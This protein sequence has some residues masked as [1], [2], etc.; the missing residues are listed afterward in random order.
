MT[1]DTA[2]ARPPEVVCP[3]C[4]EAA[5]DT[6]SWCE[7]CGADLDASPAVATPAADCVSCGAPP[8]EIADDGY[9][10]HC[11]HKQPSRRDHLVIDEGA[12]A[13]VSDR[14]IRHHQN[15][16]A[17]AFATIRGATIVVVCDGVSSTDHAEEASQ[18]AAD[19]AVSAIVAAVESDPA[20]VEAALVAGAAASQQAVEAIPLPAG[21]RGAPSCTFV[22]AVAQ[23]DEAGTTVTVGWL[24]DSR[25]FALHDDGVVQLTR[26]HSWANEAVAAGEVTAEQAELDP[27]AHSI[28]RWI[29]AD[30]PGT[31]PELASY[32][33]DSK[34][35]LLVCS[36]GLWNYAPDDAEMF[37]I[38]QR[39]HAVPVVTAEALVAFANDAGGQDNIT[40]VVVD[41]PDLTDLPDEQADPDPTT[42]PRSHP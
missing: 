26:D 28:T 9:C 32:R 3:A 12:I 13:G 2:N 39:F 31:V 18:L 8:Q 24:G 20:D 29:G 33:F 1:F 19:A 11:G 37:A 6:A 38:L 5:P 15:E 36:D 23:P 4:G 16:D 10:T 42:D 35:R 7:A 41:P 25:A 40:A 14:G 21:G 30:A 34:P 22:A 27:R 17:F